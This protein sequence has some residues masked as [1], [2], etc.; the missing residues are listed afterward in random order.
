M[1][2]FGDL[3]PMLGALFGEFRRECSD[4]ATSRRCGFWLRSWGGRSAGGA[5]AKV[6]EP[7]TKIGSAVEVILRD[8][9]GFGDSFR[10]DGL[11][12]FQQCPDPVL[13]TLVSGDT[14]T[15]G[16]SAQQF[17]I[18]ATH[19]LSIPDSAPSRRSSTIRE[20]AP[21]PRM[22]AG[23]PGGCALSVST[24]TSRA[25]RSQRRRVSQTW[26][27]D[28]GCPVRVWCAA[29]RASTSP[30]TATISP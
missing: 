21:T 12:L 19:R 28:I 8:A 13:R 7:G 4:D 17:G 11:A 6:F 3:A 30:S 9:T 26:S 25:R 22:G 14:L 20:E 29:C 15:C 16:S 10:G 2:E 24:M 23:C 5:R 27:S 1:F 18:S